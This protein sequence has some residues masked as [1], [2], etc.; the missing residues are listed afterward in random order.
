MLL[1][2]ASDLEQLLCMSDVIEAVERGF[3]AI[4]E[5]PSSV[6]PR[7]YVNIGT[8]DS[9]LLTMPAWAQGLEAAGVKFVT[10]FAGN[11]LIGQET[12]QS[13]YVL[14]SAETG[15]ALALMDGKYLTAIRTAATS[16]VATRKMANERVPVVAIFG[17]GVQ[18]RFHLR[19]MQ[20]VK[21]I[22]RAIVVGSSVERS[23]HFARKLAGAVSFAV[24]PGEPSMALE[25]A[26]LIC[27]CTTSPRP[28]FGSI[29]VRPGTHINAVGAF[30]PQTRELDGDTIAR[31]RVVID[32]WDTS[33]REAGEI[34]IPLSQGKITKSHVLG[35]MAD[36]V[37]DRI[38]P[39][40]SPDDITIF[41]SS[42]HPIEDLATAQLAYQKAK[43]A[44]IGREITL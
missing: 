41:K 36:L 32:S 13:L 39:R 28:L 25:E 2:S 18:A 5:A 30:S 6:P 31:A 23:R 34:L 20:E 11:R 33:G 38:V 1:L 14:I 10:S 22:E 43:E 29:A 24:A 3:R 17:T 15:E 7:S 21:Q 12:V 42:G 8:E 40:S 19:A 27:T 9:V 26:R 44:S 35:E 16:A 4:A 37:C